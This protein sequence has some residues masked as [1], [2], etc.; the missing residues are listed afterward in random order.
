MVHISGLLTDWVWRV[1]SE[2]SNDENLLSWGYWMRHLS[3][4]VIHHEVF[5]WKRGDD[6][7]TPVTQ[8]L[9]HNPVRMPAAS[10]KQTWFF[11]LSIQHSSFSFIYWVILQTYLWRAS[12][13]SAEICCS[14]SSS[15]SELSVGGSAVSTWAGVRIHQPISRPMEKRPNPTDTYL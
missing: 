11:C 8:F 6:P 1:K 7:N 12:I 14:S 2:K 13:F 10:E 3:K 4:D 15:R 5:T 9:Y